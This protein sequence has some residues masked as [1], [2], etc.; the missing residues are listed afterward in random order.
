VAGNNYQSVFVFKKYNSITKKKK[1]TLNIED[2]LKE[3]EK[4]TII[5]LKQ[6]VLKTIR[7]KHIVDYMRKANKKAGERK[8]F[9]ITYYYTKQFCTRYI[10]SLRLI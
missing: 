1:L 3:Q 2:Y 10:N 8:Y 9:L 5:V 6:N 7:F 4:W